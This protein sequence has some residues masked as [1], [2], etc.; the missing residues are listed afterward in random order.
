M[1]ISGLP[2]IVG[3]VVAMATFEG[4]NYVLWQQVGRVLFKFLDAVKAGKTIDPRMNYL[5]K[6]YAQLVE[7][8]DDKPATRT[9][10]TPEGQLEIYRHRAV[11]LICDTYHAVRSSTETPAKAWNTHMFSIIAAARAHTEY[12]ALES[13]ISKV[14]ALPASTSPDLRRVLTN[15]CSLFGLATIINPSTPNGSSFLSTKSVSIQELDQIRGKVNELL[16]TLL[17]DVIALTDAWDFTDASLCSAIGM[18]DGNA[19]ERVMQ[20]VEQ[21][22]I[23]QR[24]YKENGGV[25]QPGWVNWVDP[26]LKAKSKL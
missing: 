1:A 4:E 2:D 16:E 23:N 25:F 14:R 22:P 6:G 9:V 13:F 24:A 15:L 12:I 18:A 7:T 17:P 3:A 5:A 10:L 20:W 26:V 11:R 8:E 19:Y 21:M